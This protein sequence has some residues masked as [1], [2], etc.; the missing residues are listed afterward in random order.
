[1]TG[2]IAIVL[3]ILI[4]ALVLFVTEKLRMDVV[5]L[6]VLSVLALSGVTTPE[7]ALGGFSNPAV[8]TVWAMFILSAGL[9]AAGIADLIGRQ[10]LKV[11]G[12]SETG[13]VIVIMLTTGG[14]SAF[15]SNIGVAALMLPVVMDIARKT[16][17][18]P[19]RLLMPMAFASLLGGLTTLIG[20]PPNLVASNTLA[21]AGHEPFSLFDFA[22][23]GVPALITGTLFMAF[24]G[25]RLLPKE[26]PERFREEWEKD[27]FHYAHAVEEQVLQ[28]HVTGDSPFDGLT[29]EETRLAQL[30]GFHVS[31][32]EREGNRITEI[33]GNTV[34]R[35]GDR[36][37]VEGNME[38]FEA[39]RKWQAFELASGAEIAG[40]LALKKL[41]LISATLAEDS[42]LDGLTVRETDFR[43]RFHAHLHSI[44]DEDGV[45]RNGIAS[46]RLRAGNRL[47]I[48]IQ[49]E[50][51]PALREPGDF[52]D[53]EL[54]A[55]ESISDIYP[56]SEALL[57]MAIPAE[58]YLTGLELR[59]TGLA[60][61]L[62]LRVLGIAR[63]P[64]SILFPD[65]EE[66]VLEGDKLLVHGN[67]RSISLI[68]GVQS[69]EIEEA[70]D[71]DPLASVTERAHCEVTLSPRNSLAGKTLK[72]VNFRNRFGLRVESIWRE[73]RSF[74]SHLRNMTLQFGDAL[75]LSG[76][77]EK[78]DE[79]A[80]DPDFLLLT[81]SDGADGEPAGAG[82]AILASLI[83][84]AVIASVLV[85]FLPVAIAAV[86][87]GTLMIVTRCLSIDEAHRA[88][89]WKAVFL[90][91]CMIPLGTAMK[92][93]GAATW[94]A[95]GVAAAAEPLG[96]WG[97]LIGLYLLTALATTIIPT[98]ALVVIMTSLGID[99]S[100]G[101]GIEPRWIVIA[102]AMAA[103][104]SFT[105]P[106]SHPSNVLVMGPGGYRF[107]DFIKVGSLLILV[108]MVTVIP[109]I[110]L[111]STLS[112]G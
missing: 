111:F 18:S 14:L 63:K 32:I 30:L 79:L 81:R 65:S 80:K 74:R 53:L 33:V 72:Q 42:S 1:M 55:E 46:H 17:T 28:L 44:R 75:L 13:L 15:M 86:A 107:L 4:G 26:L 98:A 48:E 7:K 112:G 2:E 64:E 19:S 8:I 106:I 82:K 58:S 29:L 59:E 61:D 9:S 51:L 66:R 103:S 41:V 50:S 96:P 109:L 23:I 99:A 93:T 5:A 39:F 105:S 108:V 104:A 49:K 76:P 91:A 54:I 45:K 3:L 89:D 90:I 88:I 52:E 40:L 10:I 36:L 31:A 67:R 11:S 21:E 87:G 62:G 43:H 24:V 60:E 47:Q 38:N 110:W 34:V 25:R 57:E 95:S 22:P 69:L 70:P 71:S 35:K 100:A 97:L 101:F 12:T 78:I 16:R 27:G 77:V 94:M 56:D 73:G 85:G 83:M 37:M 68:R 84:V 6:V 92:D 20:T 102:I